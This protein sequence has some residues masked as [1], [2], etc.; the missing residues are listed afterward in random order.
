MSKAA[1]PGRHDVLVD[2]LNVRNESL[3]KTHDKQMF[4][5]VYKKPPFLVHNHSKN[6]PLE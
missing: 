6:N 5:E 3:Q 2:E 1:G 4:A